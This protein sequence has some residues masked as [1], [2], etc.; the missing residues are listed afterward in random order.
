MR[1][2]HCETELDVSGYP[3]GS[4]GKCPECGAILIV[5]DAPAAAPPRA[6][7]REAPQRDPE[8]ERE[9]AAPA[10]PDPEPE[11]EPEPEP[12][13]VTGAAAGDGEM[14]EEE[15]P[16]T[17]QSLWLGAIILVVGLVIVAAALN[18][19][20][21]GERATPADVAATSDTAAQPAAA[22]VPGGMEISPTAPER[23]SVAAPAATL[24]PTTPPVTATPAPARPAATP[25]PAT[26]STPPATPRPA[27]T[28]PPATPRSSATN[29]AAT[30]APAAGGPIRVKILNAT[31]VNG[32][33]A[34]VESRMEAANPNIRVISVGTYEG[35]VAQTVV[36]DKHYRPAAT[37]EVQRTLGVGRVT[38]NP[39]NQR[40]YE[41]DVLVVIGTDYLP[42]RN[43]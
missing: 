24:T 18:Y 39:D 10:E 8:P 3:P 25:A 23:A 12:V 33:A 36:Y 19:F 4:R 22:A 5:P 30:T 15:E 17:R 21:G 43:Q 6:V 35:A 41:Y 29:A 2:D 20:F 31:G 34:E 26:V 14:T 1:C 27:V 13:T 32:L 16:G 28:T 40:L 42:R 9:A 7:E 11:P 37:Q 38:E